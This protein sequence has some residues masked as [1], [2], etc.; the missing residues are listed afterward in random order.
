MEKLLDALAGG[1]IVSLQL[2]SYVPVESTDLLLQ[3]AYIVLEG[4]A[5]QDP[6][7]ESPATK[8]FESELCDA[9]CVSR[10]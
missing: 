2:S 10:S 9:E 5:N 6:S 4:K 3:D 8:E 1:V 7:K